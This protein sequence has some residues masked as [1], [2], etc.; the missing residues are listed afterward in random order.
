M[1][2]LPQSAIRGP[3]AWA[4]PGAVRNVDAQPRPRPNQ[5][6]RFQYIPGGGCLCL[7]KLEALWSRVLARDTE[8][9]QKARG[10]SHCLVSLLGCSTDARRWL[11]LMVILAL[12]TPDGYLGTGYHP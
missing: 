5:N 12:V 4:S 10:V 3:A 1:H 9:W 2:Q 7:S 6:L 11:P 8:S